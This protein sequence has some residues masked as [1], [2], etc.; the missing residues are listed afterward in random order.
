MAKPTFV[1][2]VY[3]LS[4]RV[5]CVVLAL[6][7]VCA[8]AR[9][10]DDAG[11]M[12]PRFSVSA[13]ESRVLQVRWPEMERALAYARIPA[14]RAARTD[15]GEPAQRW[16]WLAGASVGAFAGAGALLAVRLHDLAGLEHA[17]SG[18]V[19]SARRRAPWLN[20]GAVALGALG[21]ASLAGALIDCMTLR[22][23]RQADAWTFRIGM[24]QITLK[25]RF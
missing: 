7:A 21:A 1:D 18:A 24:P 12:A 13:W 11:E 5:T 23:S 19:E 16:Q 14:A 15:H 6:A 10:Q 8:H 17:P 4:V 3:A 25:R 22:S 2:I 9:A 20:G